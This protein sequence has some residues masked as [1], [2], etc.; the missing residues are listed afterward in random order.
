[1]DKQGN[2]KGGTEKDGVVGGRCY[3]C[4]TQCAMRVHLENGRV[5]HVEGETSFRNKGALCPKGLA[6]VYKLYAPDRLNYPMKRTRAKGDPDPGWVRI[7][8][9]EALDTIAERLKEIRKKYGARSIAFGQGTGRFSNELCSR[10]KNCIG[11]PNVIHSGHM[12]RGPMASTTCLT[13]GHHLRADFDNSECMV[14]WGRNEAWA[15][16]AFNTPHIIENLM[17][18]GAG[19]IV[20]D[21]RFEHP[22]AHKADVYLPVRP[23]TDGALML[24]WI[25]VILEESLF[26]EDFLKNHTNA[27]FLVRTDTG[28]LLLESDSGQNGRKNGFL[29]FPEC[30]EDRSNRPECLVWD[31]KS[32]S[33]KPADE[34]GV[35]PELFGTFTVNGIKCR[36]ALDLLREEALKYTPEKAA[37]ICWTGSAEKIYKAARMFA[38]SRSACLDA[39][40]FGIQGLEGGHTNTFQTLRAMLC[41][42]AVTG[43][44]N[45][46]GGDLGSPNWKWITGEWSRK[47]GFRTMTPW[48]APDDETAVILEG[49]HPHEPAMNEYPM[50]PGLPSMIDCFKAMKTGEPYPI[51]AY[52][53][54]QG[55]PLGGWC[56]DQATVREGLTALDF[57]VD[58]DLHLTPTGHLADIILPAGLGPFE[59]GEHPII[60]PLYDRRSDEYFYIELGKRLAPDWWPWKNEADYWESRRRMDE[61]NRSQATNAGF[62]IQRGMPAPDLD[63]FKQ[64][65]QKIGKPVGFPTP[66]G[67]VEIFSQIARQHNID[68]IPNYVE[69]AQSPLKHDKADRGE[70]GIKYPLV[71]TTGARLPVYYHSEHRSSPYQRALFPHPQME[72]HPQ[73][74]ESS[75]LKSGDWAWI[76]TKTGR[77]RMKVKASPGVMPGVVS[78]KH[79]W[80]QGCPQLGLPGYGWDGS[81]ANLLCA[82]DEHDPALGVPAVRSQCCRIYPAEKEP[83]SWEAPYYG[84]GIPESCGGEETEVKS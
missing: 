64:T 51:K 62:E 42:D 65:D 18:R 38:K 48:G 36:T 28:G 32:N 82:G 61:E 31:A 41:L 81:N 7:S 3:G 84:S 74:A 66:T 54:V 24:S 50:Q 19:L 56:E 80:W 40:S 25:N 34:A 11:S 1:M 33:A 79:G 12:C 21:P 75:G 68:P 20:V 15:H 55:N 5:V 63:Y 14:F 9:E 23:G 78:M 13:V 44:I 45:R 37:E 70:T 30:I 59:R 58:M 10:M 67:R 8:W 72:V 17:D 76:E 69:P 4:H 43:N 2:S 71:L 52:V 6:S 29:P 83:Y 16:P 49:P 60:K 47:G 57:L 35:D 53:M 46:L 77:I 73:T 22:L 26:D 27:A 39:G